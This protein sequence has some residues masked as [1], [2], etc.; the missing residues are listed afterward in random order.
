M[1]NE[2]ID[3]IGCFLQYMYTGE[4]F[5]RR[6]ESRGGAQGGLEEDPSAPSVDDTGEQLLRHARIYT[7]ADKLGMQ[8]S[9]S[10]SLPPR[11]LPLKVNPSLTLPPLTAHHRHSRPSPTPRSIALTAP[12]AAKSPTPGSSTRTPRAKTRRYGGRSPRSGL[13]GR[14]CCGTR[15]RRSSNAC[16]W[17]F[18][19]L[20][21]MC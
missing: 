13:S 5:P 10:L 3:A 8:V 21:S 16:V 14:T 18:R 2:H 1:P 7:L 20:A 6:I 9:A 4:Y 19:S 12:P 11:P 17:S 15:P